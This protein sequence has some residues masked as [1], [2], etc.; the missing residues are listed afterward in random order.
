MK[1]ALI[2]N[3]NAGSPYHG[4]NY[5]SYYAARGW[6]ASGMRA[7]IVCSS[8]SHKLGRLP[9]VEGDHLVEDIDGIR[10]I[11]LRTRPFAGNVGRARNYLEFARRLRDLSSIVPEPVDYVVCS[12]PP[13][14]WIWP[15]RSFARRKRAALVFEARDLWPD[16]I[17]E[18]TRAGRFNPVA[19]LMRLGERSA[20]RHADAVVSVNASAVKIMK[21]RGLDDDRFWA[22]PNGTTLDDGPAT[23]RQTEAARLCES[24]RARGK[25]VVGYAGALSPVYGLSYLVEAARAIG[26][27]GVAFV[28][29]GAGPYAARLRSATADLPDLHLAGWIP[30]DDLQG[31][32]RAVDVCYAG[33]LNVRSFSFGSDS[34]K[35]Y[36]YMKAA[37]PILHAIADE[38]SVVARTGC[39]V[40][41]RPEDTQ[42]LVAGLRRLMA[43]SDSERQALGRA[44]R[45]FLERNRSYEVLTERWLRLF[46]ALDGRG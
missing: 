33:L 9:D 18:T 46:A 22:I 11:W 44:G 8:F 23:D 31:F 7:T 40:R 25:L 29:A 43:M 30:K 28:L 16:V 5:R 26:D 37:R 4:P 41:V 45:R 35:L 10:Y 20:Y 34:T 15:C 2:V 17:F 1:H 24:L 39:G 27:A 12:S 6:V 3:H 42:D 13:P 14:L 38:D 36:E 21:T 32:L 19:W